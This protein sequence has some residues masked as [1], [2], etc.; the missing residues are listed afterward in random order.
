L[1]SEG[2]PLKA[3]GPVLAQRKNLVP[4]IGISRIYSPGSAR[5]PLISG[6]KSLRHCHAMRWNFNQGLY[7]NFGIAD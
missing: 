6:A 5:R 4:N 7:K 3:K 1:W 2:I